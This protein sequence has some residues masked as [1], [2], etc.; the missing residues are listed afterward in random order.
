MET[1]RMDWRTRGTKGKIIV[2][3]FATE[4]ACQNNQATKFS[5]GV[6]LSD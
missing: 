3:G 5:N 4:L 2:E 1:P 6:D